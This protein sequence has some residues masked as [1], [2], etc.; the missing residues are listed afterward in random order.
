MPAQTTVPPLAVLLS[1]STT[2]G[3]TGAKIM[4]ASRGTGG[5]DV[6]SPVQ[7]APRLSAKDRACASPG[8]VKA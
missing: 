8:F 2:S 4:A 7:T 1:A 5:L 6:E 3:P